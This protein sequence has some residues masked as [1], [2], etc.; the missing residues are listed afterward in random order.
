MQVDRQ[1]FRDGMARFGAA[2]SVVTSI[3]PSGPVGFTASAV[4][5]V[6]DDPPMLLVCMNRASRL[7]GVFKDSGMLCINALAASQ[8]HLSAIFAGKTDLDMMGRFAI[9]EWRDLV[10]GAPVLRDCIA[11]FDCRIAEVT[12]VGTHSVFFC[13]VAEILIGP[14]Q[15]GLIYFGR[16]YHSVRSMHVS[17][18]HSDASR[19]AACA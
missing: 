14:T 17:A 13:R 5:S 7:N 16:E 9:A 12:E 15:E 8:Q 6:T 19:A 2:V 3:G 1:A 10:T 18:R 4:C 11:S